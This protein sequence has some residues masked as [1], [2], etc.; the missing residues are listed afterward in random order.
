[1]EFQGRNRGNSIAS[2]S[3]RT[4][5]VFCTYM[6][7][8]VWAC[9]HAGVLCMCVEARGKPQM[10]SLSCS[11]T[12]SFWIG[13]LP[14]PETQWFS[15]SGWSSRDLH[16]FTPPVLGSQ[17]ALSALIWVLRT[18]FKSSCL[19][20]RQF[21]PWAIPP[22]L[23]MLFEQRDYDSWLSLWLG[24]ESLATDQEHSLCLWRCF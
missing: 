18:Q 22:D 4:L 8:L 3:M 10:Y 13:C 20:G 19:G 7:M 5:H 21:T 1:M 14:G 9:D 6:L 24:W 17:L 23:Q 12:L 16:G 11:W 2:R 15:V